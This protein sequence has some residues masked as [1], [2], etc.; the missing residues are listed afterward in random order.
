MSA[1]PLF[2]SD[3]YACQNGDLPRTRLVFK[4]IDSFFKN[5]LE[6]YNALWSTYDMTP[7]YILVSPAPQACPK[8]EPGSFLRPAERLGDTT[9]TCNSGAKSFLCIFTPFRGDF[10]RTIA[11]HSAYFRLVPL[12]FT[13]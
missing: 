6:T 10:P 8:N 1:R 13:P 5:F 9:A 11:A 12:N 4:V 2:V 3:E 7:D